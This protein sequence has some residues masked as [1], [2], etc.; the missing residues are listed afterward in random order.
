MNYFKN[1]NDR[2]WEI[3]LGLYPGVLIGYRVYQYSDANLHILY[4]PFIELTLELS[5]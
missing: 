5:K 2:F 3:S 1:N 4:I